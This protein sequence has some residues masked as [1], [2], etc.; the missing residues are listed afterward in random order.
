VTLAEV[1][2]AGVVRTTKLPAPVPRPLREVR[3]KLADLLAGGADTEGA[4]R[5]QDLTEAWVRVVLT[6]TVRP[7]APMER[8]RARWPHTLV[9]DFAPEGELTRAAADLRRLAATADPVQ[10]CGH[11]V[12]FTSGGSASAD[13]QAVLSDVVEA[14]MRKTDDH[15][16]S[17]A[18]DAA[19]SIDGWLARGGRDDDW[20][21]EAARLPDGPAQADGNTAAA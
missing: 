18:L 13:Q 15:G 7:A 20:L 3:G 6:D 2:P 16:Q 1:D 12:E 14:A 11:F 19:G 4:R 5:Q 21:A 8:L 17:D 9:L 10:L